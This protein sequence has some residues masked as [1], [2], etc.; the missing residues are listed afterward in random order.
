M[1]GSKKEE[2]CRLGASIRLLSRQVDEPL[3]VA[4]KNMLL[5]MSEGILFW[6]LP[7]FAAA[8]TLRSSHTN[9]SRLP[10]GI[11]NKQTNRPDRFGFQSVSSSAVTANNSNSPKNFLQERFRFR[12]AKFRD[13]SLRGCRPAGDPQQCVVPPL[14]NGAPRKEA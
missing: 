13:E 8:A 1:N 9:A 5:V 7:S 14:E 6:L 10:N 11:K 12:V 4:E 2:T 3:M